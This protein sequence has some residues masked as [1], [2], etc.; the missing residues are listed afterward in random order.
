MQPH[1]Y[2]NINEKQ[3]KRLGND[4]DLMEALSDAANKIRSYSLAARRVLILT[5]TL[6]LTLHSPYFKRE[7]LDPNPNPTLTI[8]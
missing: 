8:L 4:D 6:T 5:P 3:R 7:S 1:G 2:G